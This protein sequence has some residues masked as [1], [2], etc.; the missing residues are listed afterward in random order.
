MTLY[1]STMTPNAKTK[2]RKNPPNRSKN[3]AVV[4]FQISKEMLSGFRREAK[5]DG[6]SL[7]A[8]IRFRLA[9]YARANKDAAQQ[10]PKL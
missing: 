3:D 1:K 5:R 7:S 9:A 2:T 8:W 6:L 4:S 10:A